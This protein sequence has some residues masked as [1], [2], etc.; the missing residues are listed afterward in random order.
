MDKANC[1]V[2]NDYEIQRG[3]IMAQ[4]ITE[5]KE[6]AESA[7]NQVTRSKKLT[8]PKFKNVT[9]Y[10]FLL[11]SVV[12]VFIFC[13]I[14]MGGLIIA[15]KDYNA[16]Q[17]LF[18]SPWAGMGGFEHFYNFVTLPNF[19]QII[20][21]TLVISV[22]SIVFNT[23]LP[24]ILALIVNEIIC[25]WF[26]NVVKTI[27]YAPYFIS[28]VV[29]VGML[30][31]FCDV[32]SGIVTNIVALFGAEDV[33]LM[34]STAAFLPL[35]IISGLWQGLGW[36]SIIYM[37]ALANVD[38]ALHEAAVIDG[39]GRLRRIW[40]INLPAILPM[41]IIMLIMSVGNMLNVGFEKVYLMKTAGN[42]PVSQ[43]IST[44][45][46]EV[47]LMAMLPQ[48]SF[49][50]A[51]GLFNSIINIILLASANFIAKHVSQTSLW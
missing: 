16:I 20:Q 17:G 38:P 27:S 34:N 32:E 37:G 11:P 6:T 26:K 35:Y 7:Q 43:I 12:Y 33:D 4:D 18:G 5:A 44:Y 25:K 31:T 39:A 29:V 40:E 1:R 14:P 49:A 23:I 46:Y 24:I 48:Y 22:T 9:L 19:W 21:N 3:T 42:S 47:S 51:I 13:Y 8:R 50:T 15:F 30:F 36:W 2:Y 10:L 41:T 28:T 45:T